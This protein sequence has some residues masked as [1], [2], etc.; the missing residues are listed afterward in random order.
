[1]TPS[2]KSQQKQLMS[3]G[4]KIGIDFWSHGGILN[5][6]RVMTSPDVHS[7]FL[8][9]LSVNNFKYEMIIDDV[10][11]SLQQD[12]IAQTT[13]RSKRSTV[14]SGQPNFSLFW[15]FNEIEFYLDQL[16]LKYPNLVRKEVIGKS[17]EMRDIIGIRVSKNSEFGRNPIIFI[18]AGTHSR[19][20][21]GIQSSL[22]FL[23]QLVENSTVSDELLDKVDYVFVPVVNPDGY[24]YTW[25]ED[26][27]WRK[28]RRYVNYTCT[29]ID[30]N[31]VSDF[32]LIIQ[33]YH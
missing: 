27:L 26:R 30:L 6:S 23:H 24:V 25:E 31:R 2:T 13:G 3:W 15:K 21:A 19:E 7:S 4:N 9:F 5:P 16:P 17:I 10:E 29:G 1:M 12:K 32:Y 28:N 8:N 20:W 14:E 33:I 22:Y 18:D 11:Q